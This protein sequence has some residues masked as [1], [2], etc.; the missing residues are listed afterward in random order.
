MAIINGNGISV[1][2]AED[3]KENIAVGL[4]LK[5]N[6]GLSVH[7]S[8]EE[9][10]LLEDFLVHWDEEN[11]RE[12]GR[13]GREREGKSGQREKGNE[14]G[15][16]GEM[17]GTVAEA[18]RGYR[19]KAEGAG[20]RIETEKTEREGG[21][22]RRKKER[23]R[24]RGER[25]SKGLSNLSR[26]RRQGRRKMESKGKK[27]RERDQ[28]GRRRKGNETEGEAGEEA[29]GGGGGREE[30]GEEGQERRREKRRRGGERE[31][32]K[33]R[34]KRKKRGGG[35]RGGTG[36]E[37]VRGK[38][39]D[40]KEGDGRAGRQEGEERRQMADDEQEDTERGG[41]N[42]ELGIDVDD[43]EDGWKNVFLFS[44]RSLRG[45]NLSMDAFAPEAEDARPI[46]IRQPDALRSRELRGAEAALG[47]GNNH[48]ASDTLMHC[49]Y[50][51]RGEAHAS[52]N[53]CIGAFLRIMYLGLLKS[54]P[55]ARLR[56]M[57]YPIA[58]DTLMHC[59]HGMRGEAHASGTHQL[60]LA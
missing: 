3:N 44:H 30:K 7:W 47:R 52:A 15:G 13:I 54:T 43:D 2:V 49:I 18:R 24:V 17:E 4:A 36:R 40:G 27:K 31:E 46:C 25:E 6:V 9:Q 16:E 37:V 60:M 33:S 41:Q 38:E 45:H 10:S 5:H 8:R 19:G 26:G 59:D 35:R 22:R 55:D 53:A 58:S 56:Q 32:S 51:M 34:G 20:R 23:K 21:G 12:V 1:S 11:G 28:E 39:G 50:G 42:E 14:G 48:I 57:H 29:K